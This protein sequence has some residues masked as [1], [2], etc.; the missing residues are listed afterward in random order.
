MLQGLHYL[1]L[2]RSGPRAVQDRL[3]QVRLGRGGLPQDAQYPLHVLAPPPRFSGLQAVDLLA[4]ERGV[5]AEDLDRL[6]GLI[7]VSV[8]PDH[9]PPALVHLLL[10]PERRVR[11][12]ALRIVLLDRLDHPS[13]LVDL[14]EVLVG[15]RLHPVRQRLD[16]V[17]A[18]EGVDRVRHAGLMSDHLLG[19]QGDP[20]GLLGRKCE[21]LV[22]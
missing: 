6:L 20:D 15:G 4:L 17:G 22:V 3:H 10:V 5:D 12:L 2:R 8:D 21:G 18:A 19:P 1:A 9:D 16:E 7:R 14:A 11:D 13:E